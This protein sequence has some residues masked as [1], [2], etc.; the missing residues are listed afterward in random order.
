MADEETVDEAAS[1]ETEELEELEV[2]EETGD[3]AASA[4]TRTRETKGEPVELKKVTSDQQQI[5]KKL[6][7]GP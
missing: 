6:R 7:C 1:A 4:E 3:A 2:V 5:S